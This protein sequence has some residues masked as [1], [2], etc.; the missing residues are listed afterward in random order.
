[1]DDDLL[2][3][4]TKEEELQCFKLGRS[5]LDDGLMFMTNKEEELQCFKLGRSSLD[6]DPL[7]MTNKEEESYS[8]SN[9]V[10]FSW[11]MPSCI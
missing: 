2:F 9:L 6:D 5:S 8:V 1:M 4:T 7:F 10:D 11:M 3:M